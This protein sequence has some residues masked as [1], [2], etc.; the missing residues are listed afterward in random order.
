MPQA[1][2]PR[3]V[4]RAHKICFHR[5]PVPREPSGR[6]RCGV[7]FMSHGRGRGLAIRPSLHEHKKPR[8]TSNRSCPRS[9]STSNRSPHQSP[10]IC[11]AVQPT[12][13][14]RGSRRG[15]CGLDQAGD[16][17]SVTGASSSLLWASGSPS[18]KG[19]CCSRSGTANACTKAL[20]PLLEPMAGSPAELSLGPAEPALRSQP[21]C[22]AIAVANYRR[23]IRANL[24]REGLAQ[25]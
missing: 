19:D 12:C 24:G 17:A 15:T 9:G 25:G 10:V 11:P 22:E 5:L 23:H 6:L 3:L 8:V 20:N 13:P 4:I 21:L 7:S 14:Q 18:V 16:N 1:K 2:K